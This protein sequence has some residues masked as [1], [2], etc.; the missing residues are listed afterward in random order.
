[1][2]RSLIKS[3]VMKTA[4]NDMAGT[5]AATCWTCSDTALRLC[6]PGG[7]GEYKECQ[8]LWPLSF[9]LDHRNRELRGSSWTGEET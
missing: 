6:C 1:M 9:E 4:D 2:Y 8:S 5:A 7:S 3:I